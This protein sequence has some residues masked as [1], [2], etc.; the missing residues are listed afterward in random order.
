MV[1]AGGSWEW[2]LLPAG[3]GRERPTDHLSFHVRAPGGKRRPKRVIHK[4]I[5]VTLRNPRRRANN[6]FFLG[7]DV[8][9]IGFIFTGRGW[10]IRR[11]WK[12]V[13]HTAQFKSALI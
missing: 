5:R 8:D 13:A 1:V 6:H 4:F 3:A 10:Q 2:E 12:V 9:W 11:L 7:Q